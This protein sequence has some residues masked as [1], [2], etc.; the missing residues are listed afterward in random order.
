MTDVIGKTGWEHFPHEA[1]MGVRGYG[2]TKEEAFENA[3][4]ALTAIIT[5][6]EKV[7]LNEQIE[8]ECEGVDDEM[9]LVDWLSNLIFEMDTRG[10]LFGRFEVH[11]EGNILKAKAWGEKVDVAKHQPAVEVKGASYT[12]LSVRQEKDGSWTAQCVVDV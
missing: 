7:A 1:D 10:M 8:I 12:M 2:A 11:I 6:L 4:M 5:D 3:A 9:L